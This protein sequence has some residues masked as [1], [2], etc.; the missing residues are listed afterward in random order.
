M[1][2]NKRFRRTKTQQLFGHLVSEDGGEAEIRDL[3]DV[4]F[5]Q[6]E[7][8]RLEVAMGNP[9][10]VK[11]ILEKRLKLFKLGF[12]FQ[13]VFVTQQQYLDSY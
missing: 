13:P 9:A 2:T 12:H 8:F 10:V 3:E 5:G 1:T 7:V 11:E 6:E 4:V